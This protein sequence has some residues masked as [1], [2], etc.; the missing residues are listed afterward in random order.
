MNKTNVL[1]V[2]MFYQG[3]VYTSCTVIQLFIQS[4]SRTM[5]T[6]D[7]IASLH[8][9]DAVLAGHDGPGFF[10]WHRAYIRMFV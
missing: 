6:Y 10:G 8:T 9:G 5:N 7:I 4:V 2:I 1:D 3:L